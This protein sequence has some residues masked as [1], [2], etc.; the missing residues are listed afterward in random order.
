MR[1]FSSYGPIDTELHYYAPRTELL[2]RA[3]LQVVGENP[4]KGGRYTTVWGPQQTGKALTQAAQYGR[5]LGLTEIVLA[6]FVEA[7]DD[8]HRQQ[9]ETAYHDAPTGVT[10]TPVFL[11]TGS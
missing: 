3:Y 10:V 5:Q 2:D 4:E 6:N 9:Y 1:K 8:A 11:A 7:I